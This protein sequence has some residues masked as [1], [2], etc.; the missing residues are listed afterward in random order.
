M[1]N[2][3]GVCEDVFRL[4]TLCVCEMCFYVPLLYGTI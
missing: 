1:E 2:A 3:L 4:L